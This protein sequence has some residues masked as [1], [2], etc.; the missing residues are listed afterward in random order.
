M[1]LRTRN[2]GAQ[3]VAI[4]ETDGREL[5]EDALHQDRVLDRLALPFEECSVNCA[6]I[7]DI[8]CSVEFDSEEL[9][10][11]AVRRAP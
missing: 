6:D 3:M 10:A 8:L 4:S 7:Q 1:R 2:H 11:E 9:Y 5:R